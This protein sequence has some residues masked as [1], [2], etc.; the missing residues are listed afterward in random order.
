MPTSISQFHKALQEPAMCEQLP[1][2]DY[3]DN[4]AVRTNGAFVAGYELD[5]L[6]TYFASDD[7][8][9]RSKT[10]LEALLRAIPEQSMRVQIRYEIVEN[11]DDLIPRY[12][13]AARSKSKTVNEI[14]EI[15]IE[16]WQSKHL[17]GQ[18]LRPLLH[19]YFIWNPV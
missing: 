6:N 7:T 1:V 12:T 18:Y 15:R 2:R 16:Q 10:M 13:N 9:E 5:G 17:N 11:L 8:R 19:A 4:L 14:D 3:F